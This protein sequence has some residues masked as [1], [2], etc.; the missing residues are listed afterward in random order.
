MRFSSL[1]ERVAGGGAEAWGVHFQ[2]LRERAAG[3]QI[4]FLTIG[5]PDQPAPEVVIE[6]AREALANNI[7]GY[8]PIAGL[9][10]VR[11]A[12]AARIARRTGARC[13]ES[14][15]VLA[16]GAQAALY[17]VLQCIAGPGDEVIIAEPVYAT[18]GAVVGACG[19]KMVTTPLRPERGFHPD[20]AAMEAAITPRT[21]AIW[22]NS[23]HNPSG[24]VLERAEL[25][26]IAALARRHD[27]WLLADEVYEDLAYA[28]P[29]ISAWSLADMAGRTIVVSSLSKSH[30]IPGFRF[31]WIAGPPELTL[32]AFNLVL[33]MLYGGPPFIQAAVMPALARDLPEVAALRE[34]Y[35]RRSAAFAALL[36]T[37]PDCRIAAPEGGMFALLDVRPTGLSAQ[38]FAEGLLAEEAIAVLPCDAFGPSAVGH[39]RISL[40]LPDEALLAAGARIV[41]YAERVAKRDGRRLAS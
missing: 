30:A 1:T 20:L 38:A 16:P 36:A 27:L 32:H 15:I 39:L 25:E 21:R 4:T 6:A 37:A 34:D 40:T 24:A 10:A 19:A 31:G 2:A 5:D 26:A 12:V 3:R 11:A 29:H 22:I 35:R 33:C 28:R 18:Y 14:K 23:P 8:A 9:P 41:A 13:E 7:K 17:I